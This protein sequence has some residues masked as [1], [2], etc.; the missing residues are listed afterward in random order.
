VPQA[1]ALREQL[2]VARDTT[3]SPLERQAALAHLTGAVTVLA[4]LEKRKALADYLRDQIQR[5]RQQ[6]HQ[7]T[8][9]A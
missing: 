8:R 1:E 5:L 9:E 3:K 6:L 2:A 4:A 7:Q